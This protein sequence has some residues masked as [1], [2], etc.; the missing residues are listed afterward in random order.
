MDGCAR[1]E[2]V[3][4][5]ERILIA[6]ARGR[7]K[8]R[9]EREISKCGARLSVESFEMRKTLIAIATAAAMLP[10]GALATPH[11]QI[12]DAQREDCLMTDNDPDGT[13][14]CVKSGKGMTQAQIDAWYAEDAKEQV[15]MHAKA[16][17]NN[18][19]CMRE[20]GVF[21]S[22]GVWYGPP[23]KEDCRPFIAELIAA[24]EAP[25]AAYRAESITP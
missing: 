18:M 10:A 25:D 6:I 2:V 16:K 22:Y 12:T 14:W 5:E 8:A 9:K 24:A 3:T 1:V 15:A 11:H 19:N 13:E 20:L 4:L 21:K 17:P 23:S 7:R